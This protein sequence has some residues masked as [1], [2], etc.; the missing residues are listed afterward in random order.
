MQIIDSHCHLDMVEKRG[1]T[2]E[3][4]SS[5]LIK[6]KVESIVQIAADPDS[7]E[8]SKSLCKED[9]PFKRYF[10]VGCHPGEAHEIDSRIVM[11]FARDNY[12]DSHLV[13]IGEIGLEYFYTKE[14]ATI[15]KQVFREYM[16]LAQELDLPV[17]IH[18]REA[19]ED[20][21]N[22]L[23][24]YAGVPILIH[25]FTGN[26]QQALDY[27]ELGCYISFSGIVT[28]KNADSLREAAL[29]VP[30]EKM[31]VETDAPF[32]APVPKRGKTNQP[33]YVRYTLQFLANLKGISEEELAGK[34]YHNTKAFYRI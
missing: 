29:V 20:T 11:Q 23:H 34:T 31:L 5:N 30:P 25:C 24:S 18:T 28:F 13:A 8:F 17:V 7:L 15:Q 2:F 33:A 14:T 9:L 26:R 3:E 32:L 19:H 10:T 21:M 16:N 12:N 6:N 27:L 22:I 4:I 1:I